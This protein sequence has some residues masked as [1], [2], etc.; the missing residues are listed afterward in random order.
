MIL[1]TAVLTN[2]QI[3]L[4]CLACADGGA[5]FLKTSTGFHPAGG[6]SVEHVRLLSRF[7]SKRG[8]GVKAAGGIRDRAAVE[9]M[10]KA[11]ASR[12]GTSSGVAIMRGFEGGTG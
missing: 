8:M 11:G 10:I 3:E 9:T 5:D 12:I 7:A 2:E 6:A 4:G 1:E